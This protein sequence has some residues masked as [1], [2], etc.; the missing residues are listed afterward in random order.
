[1]LIRTS[2]AICVSFILLLPCVV[3]GGEIL[4]LSLSDAVEAAMKNN[5]MRLVSSASVRIAKAQHEQ[6]T[7]GYWPQLKLSVSATRMDHDPNFVFPQ[8]TYDIGAANATPL[9]EAI[10]AAQ[11]SKQGITPSTPGY[12]TMLEQLTA[13]ILPNVQKTSIPQQDVKLMDRDSLVSTLSL[14]YPLYTGGKVSSVVRQAELGIDAAREAARRTDLQVV[15]DVK[16]MY[17][18]A[19]LSERLYELGK[20]TL[21]RFEVTLELT[22]RLYKTGSGRVKKTDY[23]RTSVVVSSIRAMMETLK[24]NLE[25]SRSALAN[26]IGL[27]WSDQVVPTDKAENIEPAVPALDEAVANALKLNPQVNQVRIGVDAA[28]AKIDEAKSGHLP[29]LVLFGDVNRIDNSYHAGLM[30]DQNKKS[31]MI[32]LRI[33]LNLFEGFRTRGEVAEARARFEKINVEDSLLREGVALQVKDA[34][35]QVSRSKGQITSTREALASA[36]ENRELNTRAYQQE[37]VETKDV[38]EA[39]LMELFIHSQYQKA[40]Y[41]YQSGIASLEFLV[42]REVAERSQ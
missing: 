42:G 40:I 2:A 24:S 30:T 35:L 9:A 8:Y 4:N 25:L 34:V 41:D 11:L 6:A 21:E 31:W 18:A 17:Y 37:L 29:V 26:A 38:I 19:V 1:M 22:E 36:T 5:R 20:E 12:N 15:D 14:I 33:D 32:G 28:K 16:R 13:Q 10:A 23:L 7:S 39:Q 27:T 3:S